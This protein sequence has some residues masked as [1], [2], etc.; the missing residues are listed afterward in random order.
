MT[1]FQLQQQVVVGDHTFIGGVDYFSG[2]FDYDWRTNVTLSIFGTPIYKNTYR[3]QYNPPQRATVLYLQDYWRANPKLLVELG[4]FGELS[5]NVRYGYPNS[6]SRS[7]ADPRLGLNYEINK[8]HT[9]R[10]A[11]QS[12]LNAHSTLVSTLTPGEVASFPTEI[13]ADDGSHVRET[14]LAWE[15]QWDAKSFTTLRFDSHWVENPQFDPTSKVDNILDIKTDSYQVSFAYNRILLS[16]LGLRL[17]A[18]S[19][20]VFTDA[21][22]VFGLSDGDFWEVGAIAGLTYMRPDGWFAGFNT[23]LIHQDLADPTLSRH[24]DDIAGD[25]FGLLDVAFGK[26]FANK[27]GFF[28]F[29]VSNVFNQHFYYQKE[30]V[31]LDSIYP[32]RRI[33]FKLGF[34]F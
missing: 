32:E 25:V 13:N 26:Y 2:N 22:P 12:Y 33:G 34:N 1:D 19:K 20:N 8:D 29:G 5:E 27:R 30:F 3:Y 31:T 11:F 24:Q 15:A 21:D 7:E 28:S 9:L 10:F 18:W 17:G 16:S 4:V 14:G 23:Y 6:I